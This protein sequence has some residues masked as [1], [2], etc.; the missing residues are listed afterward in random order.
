MT[1]LR[2]LATWAAALAAGLLALGAGAPASAVPDTP[3]CVT[4]WGV[5]KR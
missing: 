2:I 4:C 3:D 5:P 1:H